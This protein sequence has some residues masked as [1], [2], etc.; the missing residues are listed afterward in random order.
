MPR[1][2]IIKG[3]LHSFLGTYTS[4]YSNYDGYWLFGF[5]VE[6]MEHVRID[7][8]GAAGKGAEGT[9]TTTARCL[10]VSKFAEQMEKAG[11]S[12]SCFQEACLDI[13]KSADSREG[14]VNGHVCSG[15]DVRFV[16]TA[17]TDHGRTFESGVSVFVAPH[18]PTIEWGSG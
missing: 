18:D 7:L 10:A 16:A 9:P 3:I 2:R 6:D 1:R 8:L 14:I 13:T 4:R 15:H 17:I 11:F 12:M 5:L